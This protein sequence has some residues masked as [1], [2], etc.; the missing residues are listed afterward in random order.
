MNIITSSILSRLP[1]TLFKNNIAIIFSKDSKQ[2]TNLVNKL[3][4]NFQHVEKHEG[5]KQAVLT[6]KEILRLST[7]AILRQS[8][9]DQLG[10]R[11]I[12]TDNIGFPKVLG[13]TRSQKN[14]ILGNPCKARMILTI[15]SMFKLVKLEPDYNISTITDPL[16]VNKDVMVKTIDEIKSNLPKILKT[17]RVTKFVP[18]DCNPLH[19]TL[20]AGAYGPKAMGGTSVHDF[21]AVSEEG[22]LLNIKKLFKLVLTPDQQ[23]IVKKLEYQTADS[24]TPDIYH[25]TKPSARLHFISEGGGKT[26]VICIGDIWTQMALKPIHNKIMTTLKKVDWDGTSSHNILAT[27]LKHYT[28]MR[29]FFCFDL[30]AATDRMPILLQK[31]VLKPIF[32]KE[33]TDLWSDLLINRDID[34]RGA[35]VRYAVGQPMGFL[36]SWSAM[37]LTHHIIIHHCFILCGVP[38]HKRTYMVIGD[39]MAISHANAA[40]KYQ[41]TL[42]SLGIQISKGKSLFPNKLKFKGAEL[43]KR[44]FLNGQE[45]SP[46]TPSQVVLSTNSLHDLLALSRTCSDRNFFRS[47]NLY[48]KYPGSLAQ[49]T[50]IYSLLK[51]MNKKNR[52]EAYIYLSSPLCDIFT[53]SRHQ[54]SLVNKVKELVWDETYHFDNKFKVFL[55]GELIDK[56]LKLEDFHLNLSLHDVQQVILTFSPL[57]HYY[58]ESVIKELNQIVKDYLSIQYNED[59]ESNGIFSPDNPYQIIGEFLKRPGPDQKPTYQGFANEKVKLQ[60]T[61]LIQFLKSENSDIL[62]TIKEIEGLS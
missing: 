57:V 50:V 46:I 1:L 12:A 52:L 62:P 26:R 49:K 20:K 47:D 38:P 8:R 17:L 6:H 15:L 55:L 28:K 37:A 14:E 25:N 27:K 34:N 56:I 4:D 59:E 24:I 23:K 48:I 5:I 10:P 29:E 42:E 35:P 41:E 30:T 45:L 53:D 51:T 9:V 7:R 40:K 33:I 18:K 32:G 11:W 16:S 60:S 19:V 31:E 39:D 44:N 43:A 22:I 36:S 3:I 61:I 54:F 21:A 58:I 2:A 13:L